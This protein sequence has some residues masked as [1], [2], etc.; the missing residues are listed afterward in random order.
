ME[1]VV[2]FVKES[3]VFLTIFSVVTIVF[4]DIY[5]SSLRNNTPEALCNR[6]EAD[7]ALVFDPYIGRR[8]FE[9]RVGVP[10]SCTS[11]VKKQ[12]FEYTK[13]EGMIL[14]IQA[15]INEKNRFDFSEC[16]KEPK[17]KLT[18][19]IRGEAYQK[20]I[21]DLLQ[22]NFRVRIGGIQDLN[23]VEI[24]WKNGKSMIKNI[25]LGKFSDFLNLAEKPNSSKKNVIEFLNKRSKENS[26]FQTHW[27][28]FDSSFARHRIVFLR[29]NNCCGAEQRKIYIISPKESTFNRN[30]KK[31]QSKNN[32]LIN[33][34]CKKFE[35]FELSY[36][37]RNRFNLG[38]KYFVTKEFCT[39]QLKTLQWE[40][41]YPLTGYYPE[42]ILPDLF[43]N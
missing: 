28:S 30:E 11:E 25:M 9:G 15:S 21:S 16:E 37:P 10:S 7:E 24:S 2:K 43:P 33:H 27:N 40:Y 3:W 6:F 29:D 39:D 14:Y 36:L 23:G 32:D 41:E 12:F 31:F 42:D 35:H 18:K 19:F 1:K 20:F 17:C 13:D 26:I 5:I 22:Y 8:Y 4:L 34:L 38:I